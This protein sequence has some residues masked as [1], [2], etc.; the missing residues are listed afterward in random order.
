MRVRSNFKKT[1]HAK[2]PKIFRF[3]PILGRG[4]LKVDFEVKRVGLPS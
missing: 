3:Q 1:L 4:R 2:Q